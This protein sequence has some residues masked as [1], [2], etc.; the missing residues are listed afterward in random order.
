MN[1]STMHFPSDTPITMGGLEG[2]AYS[3]LEFETSTASVVL[4]TS[5]TTVNNIIFRD[6]TPL[7]VFTFDMQNGHFTATGDLASNSD[8]RLKEN[9][10]TIENALAKVMEMRGVYFDL[11][12]NPGKRKVGVIAQEVEAILPEVVNIA[13]DEEQTKSV[14]YANMVGLLIEAIKDLKSEVD[15]LKDQ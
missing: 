4:E 12:A 8:E 5:A 15:E 11:K 1:S 14:A 7:D 10:E 9:I 6:D 13:N 3:A 2:S